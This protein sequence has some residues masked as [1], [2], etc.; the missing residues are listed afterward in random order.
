[1]TKIEVEINSILTSYHQR[2]TF[3]LIIVDFGCMRLST[4]YEI[5]LYI[6]NGVRSK[7]VNIFI[8]GA[9][10]SHVTFWHLTLKL[11]AIAKSLIAIGSNSQIP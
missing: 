9:D 11:E 3:F 10:L 5:W 7:S 4:H 6:F 8:S 1:M 2:S